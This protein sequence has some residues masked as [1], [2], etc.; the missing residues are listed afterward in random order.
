ML[1]HKI[2]LDLRCKEVRRDIADPYE[3][4]ST[5]CRAFSS[6]EEKCPPGTFLWRLEPETSNIGMPIIIVQS[7]VL[8]NWSRILVSD[9]FS[10]KPYPP[11]DIK[12]MNYLNP[13]N[14]SIG[15]RFRYRLR[16]NPSVCRNGKRIG[17]YK[18][19]EQE[20]W[21]LRQGQSKGFSTVTVHC[22]QEQML[23]GNRRDG[24]TIR[25][26]SVLYDGV[27]RI[28]DPTAFINASSIGIGHGKTMGLGLLSVIPIR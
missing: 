15:T 22:S 8:P 27:L 23:T 21:L 4:H 11:I 28:T 9:W 6:S 1:L 19:E 26:F 7:T 14:L 5:L 13:G 20:E 24:G 3:M 10:G 25:V 12:E 18:S 17:L 16:A 2:L